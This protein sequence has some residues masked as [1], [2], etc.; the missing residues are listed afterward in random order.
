MIDKGPSGKV[1]GADPFHMSHFRKT[2]NLLRTLGPGAIEVNLDSS[3]LDKARYE[4]HSR[5][6]LLVFNRGSIYEYGS[7]EP[8]CFREL[9]DS[10]SAGR[11]FQSRIRDRYPYRRV[12]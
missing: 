7:V 10:P 4:R 12:S 11:F 9:I 8:A 6:L 5:R 3:A 2:M 1:N